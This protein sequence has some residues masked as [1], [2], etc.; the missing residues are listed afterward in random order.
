MILTF[1]FKLKINKSESF[2]KNVIRCNEFSRY[3]NNHLL[4]SD[5]DDNLW[6]YA[7]WT[8]GNGG[9]L[10][11]SY[12][13]NIGYVAPGSMV[14]PMFDPQLT[15]AHNYGAM[16]AHFGSS[17]TIAIGSWGMFNLYSCDN[18]TSMCDGITDHY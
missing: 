6:R 12:W 4:M 16:G 10:L 15:M 1:S 5:L 2:F 18:I 9:H 17:N 13:L 3:E 7:A 8:N 11:Y 14:F